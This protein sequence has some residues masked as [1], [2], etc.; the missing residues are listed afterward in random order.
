M[1]NVRSRSETLVQIADLIAG[2]ILRAVARDDDEGL[3]LLREKIRLLYHF[4]P[5][6]KNPPS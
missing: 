4:Q 1:L 5:E 2:M 6:A 3:N